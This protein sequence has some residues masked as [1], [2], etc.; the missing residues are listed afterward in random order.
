MKMKVGEWHGPELSGFGVHLVYV[1]DLKEGAVPELEEVNEKVLEAWH[2]EQRESFT[3]EFLEN[4]KKR[5][6][7]V[8][9][10]VPAERLIEVPKAAAKEESATEVKP[11]S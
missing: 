11:A 10:E 3:A 2:E 7:I 5:H 9:D 8:I 1:Y 4:L 6:D